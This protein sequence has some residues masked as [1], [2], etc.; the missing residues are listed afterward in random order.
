MRAG[1]LLSSSKWRLPTALFSA[2]STDEFPSRSFSSTEIFAD[3]ATSFA[4]LN[5]FDAG[6]CSAIA[7]DDD[8]PM[9]TALQASLAGCCLFKTTPME[10]DD[11]DADADSFCASGAVVDLRTDDTE[12][13]SPIL[14]TPC[15]FSYKRT[16][17][18]LITKCSKSSLAMKTWRLSGVTLTST[19]P[20]TRESS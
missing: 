9:P 12:D 14:Y 17:D 16:N 7:I 4:D 2:V 15:N 1:T 10:D 11:V 3:I 6:C 13:A 5:C 19:L 18:V 8:G 20:K